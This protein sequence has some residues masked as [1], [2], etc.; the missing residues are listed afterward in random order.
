MKKIILLTLTLLLSS[1][2]LLFANP[3]GNSGGPYDPAH[4]ACNTPNPPWWCGKDPSNPVPLDDYLPILFIGG[5]AIGAY[6]YSTKHIVP[7]V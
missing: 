7:N 3:P 6:F 2:T 5:V 4:P 1:F